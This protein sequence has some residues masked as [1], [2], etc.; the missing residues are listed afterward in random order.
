MT[1]KLNVGGVPLGGGAPVTI[2]SM[3]NT[4]AHDVE[5]TGRW[6]RR[7]ARLSAL[8]YLIWRRQ[9]LSAH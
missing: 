9:G 6:Q 4:P 7:G 3:T 8:R 2:Q 5:S 1:R